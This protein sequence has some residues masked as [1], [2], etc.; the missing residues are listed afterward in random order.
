MYCSLVFVAAGEI[1]AEDSQWVNQRFINQE[2]KF[3]VMTQLSETELV[4]E[5]TNVS[6][7]GF[8]G[9]KC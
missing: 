7:R 8:D 9:L 2:I 1:P 3:R 5:F 4:G 6:P